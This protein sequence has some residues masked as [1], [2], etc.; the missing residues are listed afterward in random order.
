MTLLFGLARNV[1]VLIQSTEYLFLIFPVFPPVTESSFSYV[2]VGSEPAVE[3]RVGSSG[4][5]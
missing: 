5:F 4:A 2:K 1:S 3:L